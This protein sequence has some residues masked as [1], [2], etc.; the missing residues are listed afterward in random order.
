R[1]R[2]VS[3]SESSWQP[4]SL[5]EVLQNHASM[6]PDRLAFCFLIDGEEEGPRLTYAGLDRAARSLAA[7]L[8]DVA[9]PG[10]RALLLYEPGLD[11]IA[12]FFG[13]LYAGLI[14]VPAYPPR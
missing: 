10:D 14:P 6:A 11:F 8:R 3:P 9:G 2:M 5:V 7:V 12:A 4:A 1:R 13:C